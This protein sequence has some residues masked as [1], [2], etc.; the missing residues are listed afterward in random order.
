M[1]ARSS[2]AAPIFTAARSIATRARRTG[3]DTAIVRC[4]G[5]PGLKYG[6]VDLAKDDDG[7]AEVFMPWKHEIYEVPNDPTDGRWQHYVAYSDQADNYHYFGADPGGLEEN[8]LLPLVS[9]DFAD[10]TPHHKLGET[11]PLVTTDLW[12][13]HGTS[14]SGVFQQGLNGLWQ[15]LGPVSVGN[16]EHES[17][18]CNHIPSLDGTCRDPGCVG[19]SYV[20]LAGTQAIFDQNKAAIDGDA[21]P[22][23][24]G[25]QSLDT[26]LLVSVKNLAANPENAGLARR[27]VSPKILSPLDYL[28]APVVA[29]AGG[30]TV[31]LTGLPIAAGGRYRLGLTVASN[32]E[33]QTEPCPR[34]SVSV[35]GRELVSYEVHERMLAPTSLASAFVSASGGK[36]T[37]T[38]RAEN[39]GRFDVGDITVRAESLAN[40]FDSAPERLEASLVDLGASGAAPMRFVGDGKA[41]F[42]AQLTSNERLLL[43][44]QAVAP[45]RRWTATFHAWPATPLTCG[46]LDDAGNVA[47][48]AD[49]TRGS[50]AL[51]DVRSSGSARAAFF[52]EASSTGAPVAIDDVELVSTSGPLL[53]GDE[54]R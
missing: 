44:R 30:E 18:L 34:L 13:C 42:A 54:F 29:L 33:C 43:T 47:L 39:G 12:G 50:V 26:H 17:Y 35:D 25:A 48:R 2:I 41:G 5:S 15:L 1:N 31:S 3:G 22:F 40:S 21:D 32:W 24:G 19:I 36:A 6:F 27:L 28:R 10:G 4:S 20:A 11:T 52:I 8:Q 46:F 9:I 23:A 38:L 49:C 37:V 16:F 7:A 53:A 51:N 45:G 14:G